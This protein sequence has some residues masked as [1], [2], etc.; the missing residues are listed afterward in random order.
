[1]I[2]KL[3]LSVPFHVMSM[4]DPLIIWT[5][6]NRRQY[7]SESKHSRMY[8]GAEAFIIPFLARFKTFWQQAESAQAVFVRIV[9][10]LL[11]CNL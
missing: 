4:Q 2:Q 10:T 9:S 11:I 1:V 3:E 6:L 8:V 7:Q 5:C